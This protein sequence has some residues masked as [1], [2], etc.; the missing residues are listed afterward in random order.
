MLGMNALVGPIL[1]FVLQRCSPL[2]D[3]YDRHPAMQPLHAIDTHIDLYCVETRIQV[4]D[5]HQTSVCCTDSIVEQSLICC[6]NAQLS[7]ARRPRCNGAF[8][9]AYG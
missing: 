2:L 9:S 8:T 6:N 3:L 5:F 4:W 7:E 1:R